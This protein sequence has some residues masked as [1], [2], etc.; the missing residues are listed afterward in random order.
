MITIF[1]WILLKQ[2]EIKWRLAFWQYADAQLMSLLEH[3]EEIGEK[4]KPY[5]TELI[6]KAQS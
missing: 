5:L 4:I 1:R 6:H 3:P 2:K